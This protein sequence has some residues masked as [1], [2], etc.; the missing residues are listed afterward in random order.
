MDEDPSITHSMST[1]AGVAHVG[2]CVGECLGEV[3]GSETGG[4]VG[5]MGALE[6]STVG[7]IEVGESVVGARVVGA[8]VVGVWEVGLCDVG[9]F[10]PSG[11][12]DG[13]VVGA[14]DIC[15]S[16]SNVFPK[17]SGKVAKDAAW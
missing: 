10:E 2:D 15:T 9:G 1:F 13:E 3:V 12:S 6:G 4:D 11:L 17:S 5:G 14:V 8:R 16:H 7:L